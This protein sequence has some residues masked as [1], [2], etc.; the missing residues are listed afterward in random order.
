MCVCMRAC[1]FVPLVNDCLISMFI[2]GSS[3][4]SFLYQLGPFQ[5]YSALFSM[6]L[7]LP[8]LCAQRM[9]TVLE[10]P[11]K[12]R[13]DMFNPDALVA[14]AE[15]TIFLHL[16][17]GWHAGCHEPSSAA[18]QGS[19]QC[20]GACREADMA[21]KSGGTAET[22][23]TP[24]VI[25]GLQHGGGTMDIKNPLHV[26][27]A[28]ATAELVLVPRKRPQTDSEKQEAGSNFNGPVGRQ[29]SISTGASLLA[30]SDAMD[31]G[32]GAD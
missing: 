31:D 15:R 6:F 29:E 30:T 32:G 11:F 1:A 23:E 18:T 25:E 16:R 17:C 21:G 5:Y 9:V 8:W 3:F 19:A 14:G 24:W 13:H 10:D 2:Y 12:T 26:P 28:V 27:N 7:A 4:E 20:D 22:V